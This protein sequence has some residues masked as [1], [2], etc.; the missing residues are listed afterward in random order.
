MGDPKGFRLAAVNAVTL[1]PA[2]RNV[3]S[4]RYRDVPRK[5]CGASDSKHGLE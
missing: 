3:V 5:R 1:K 2:E 4:V